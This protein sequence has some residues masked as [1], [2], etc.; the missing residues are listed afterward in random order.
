VPLVQVDLR[1]G[2][3]PLLSAVAANA[4]AGTLFAWSVLVPALSAELGR[5]AVELG[6]VFSSSLVAF[7]V[8]V[9]CGGT[10]VD[11]QGPRRA[12]AVGG[13]LSGGGNRPG[14][15]SRERAVPPSRRRGVLR[16]RQRPHLPQRGLLG[17]HSGRGL[18]AVGV[19][20]ASYAA[21]PVV[22]APLGSQAVDRWGWRTA[23]SSS[24]QSRSGP[25]SSLRA[26]DCPAR[27]SRLRLSLGRRRDRWATRPRWQ[28]CGASRSE[29]S[30]RGCSPSRTPHTSRPSGACHP[31]VPASRSR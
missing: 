29:P 15:G 21:G 27:P 13:L 28:P 1:P 25:S 31:A 8:A 6:S 24:P 19:V 3:L 17:D 7:A 12:M 2:R 9:L 20:V 10:A 4:A 14:G 26:G 11:R 23:L 5:P 22:T 30:R 18:W 16:S